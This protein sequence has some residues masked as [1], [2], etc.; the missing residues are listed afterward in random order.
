[1]QELRSKRRGDVLF[2]PSMTSTTVNESLATAA[3]SQG[4]PVS[5]SVLFIIHSVSDG[6]DL[7]HCSQYPS[8]EEVLLPACSVLRIRDVVQATVLQILLD[9]EG[10]LL[11]ADFRR[12]VRDDIAARERA[13]RGQ[14]PAAQDP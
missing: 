12:H 4:E 2:W 7:R 8:E 10:T 1:M 3:A 11:D 14:F 13:L 9:F 6:L 5:S